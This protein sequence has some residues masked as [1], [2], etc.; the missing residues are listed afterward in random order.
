MKH[1]TIILLTTFFWMSC[2]SSE[3]TSNI[4]TPTKDAQFTFDQGITN[5]KYQ[6]SFGKSC[7]FIDTKQ[8]TKKVESLNKMVFTEMEDMD[9]NK[10]SD[11]I[12]F[13][14]DTM[15]QG[16]QR[17]YD[18]KEMEQMKVGKYD[19][20]VFDSGYTK[21]GKKGAVYVVLLSEG[22]R[23]IKFFGNAYSDVANAKKQFKSTVASIKFK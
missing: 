16:K 6:K 7:T 5:Y 13:W 17:V 3:H 2:S 20:L 18:N 22:N 1:V 14:I 8:P 10:R 9:E 19:A 23:T 21:A 12:W 4:I 11:L 15:L